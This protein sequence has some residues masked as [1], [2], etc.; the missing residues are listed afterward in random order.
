MRADYGPKIAAED[1]IYSVSGMEKA[2][3]LKPTIGEDGTEVYPEVIG[4]P[5]HQKPALEWPFLEWPEAWGDPE[6]WENIITDPNDPNYDPTF[7]G[8]I[9][10]PPQDPDDVP[11]EPGEPEGNDPVTPEGGDI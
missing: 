6:D 7:G 4:C 2:V 8:V 9:P 11:G 10:L 1:E 3:G 5:V